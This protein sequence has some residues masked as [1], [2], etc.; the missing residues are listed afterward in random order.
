MRTISQQFEQNTD[1]ATYHHVQPKVL[2][3]VV[4]SIGHDLLLVIPSYVFH[5]LGELRTK[6][7]SETLKFV[8]PPIG[9]VDFYMMPPAPCRMACK[10]TKLKGA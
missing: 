5:T 1:F 7:E 10:T 3:P 6:T 8:D 2:S 4:F 9:I